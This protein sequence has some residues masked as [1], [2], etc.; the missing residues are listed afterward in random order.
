[1]AWRD[2][3]AGDEVSPRGYRFSQAECSRSAP[4]GVPSEEVLIH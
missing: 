2:L 3:G 4:G 1:M